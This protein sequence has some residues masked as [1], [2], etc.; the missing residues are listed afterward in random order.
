MKIN[1][2]DEIVLKDGRQGTVVEMLGDNDL[3]LVDV[4]SSPKDWANIEVSYDEIKK[5]VRSSCWGDGDRN[6]Q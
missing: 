6:D 2:Y 3:F 1:Q 5:V 4:G